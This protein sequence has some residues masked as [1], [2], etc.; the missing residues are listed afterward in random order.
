M[1]SDKVRLRVIRVVGVERWDG[2]LGDALGRGG[3]SGIVSGFLR[4]EET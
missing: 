3:K 1:L 4:T 2:M